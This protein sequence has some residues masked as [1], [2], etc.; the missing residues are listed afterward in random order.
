MPAPRAL[1]SIG[2]IRSAGPGEGKGVPDRPEPVANVIALRPGR[3]GVLAS[4]PAVP[5][6]SLLARV[7]AHDAAAARACV[8][9]YGALVWSLARRACP[10]PD[11]AED[12]VQEIFVDVWKS[13]GRYDP[14]SG[15]ETTFVATIARRRLIDRRRR[16]RRR[17]REPLS[18]ALAEPGAAERPELSAEAALASRAVAGLRPEQRRALLLATCEGLS[19][20]EIADELS[21]PLGTVKAHVRRGLLHVKRAL[22]GEGA[23]GG[24]GP[25]GEDG[26]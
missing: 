9:R 7:A 6:P 12:A 13:A 1:A 10:D 15:S 17:P 23:E 18:E 5:P 2:C 16:E 3:R 8:E 25:R 22:F 11:E 19:H 26:R 20:S 24:E 4:P 21:L 14:A